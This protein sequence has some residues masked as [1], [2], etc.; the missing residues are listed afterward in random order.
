VLDRQWQAG[1][2][3]LAS[4]VA[5][6]EA[7]MPAEGGRIRLDCP[8]EAWMEHCASRPGF[9]M[10]PLSWGA[11]VRAC[12]LDGLG[13]RDPADRLPTAAATERNC[14]LVT[15][16]ERIIRFAA[17]RTGQHGLQLVD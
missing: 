10:V 8:A 1:G 17:P 3:A 12:G 14:A 13:H 16:D 11:C 9:E 5:A 2:A 7:A 6:W 4:A 15:C